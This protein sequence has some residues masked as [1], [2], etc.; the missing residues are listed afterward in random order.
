MKQKVIEIILIVL[1]VFVIFV[2]AASA[3]T[4]NHYSNIAKTIDKDID[5]V[6]HEI[7][8]KEKEY[9]KLKQ[10][11]IDKEKQLDNIN[12]Y[13]TTLDEQVTKYEKQ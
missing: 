11:N 1:I 4:I 5:K 9:S 13:I 10:D 2:I 7:K 12:S 3:V 6:K 8:V